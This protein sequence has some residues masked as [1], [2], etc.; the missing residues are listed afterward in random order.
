MGHTRQIDARPRGHDGALGLAD[1]ALGFSAPCLSAAEV[2]IE[3]P[4]VQNDE[5]LASLHTLAGVD[6]HLVNAGR[7]SRGGLDW[8]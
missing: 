5:R 4:V 7:D 3:V 6:P 1:S 2:R 8:D